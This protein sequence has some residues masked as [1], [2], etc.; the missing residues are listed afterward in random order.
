MVQYSVYLGDRFGGAMSDRTNSVIAAKDLRISRNQLK[1][2]PEP[3]KRY[4]NMSEE[5]R[6]SVA[7]YDAREQN[8]DRGATS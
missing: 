1:F 2:N 3:R 4:T 7:F 5:G 8:D 6:L